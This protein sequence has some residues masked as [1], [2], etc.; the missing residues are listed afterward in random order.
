MG[1]CTHTC[2]TH[3]QTTDNTHTTDLYIPPTQTPTH[4]PQTLYI[5]PRRLNIHTSQ[6]LHTHTHITHVHTMVCGVTH[7]IHYTH[8][9]IYTTLTMDTYTPHIPQL[10]MYHIYHRYK[11]AIHMHTTQT[12]THRHTPMTPDP[13]RD[14]PP[15][16]GPSLHWLLRGWRPRVPQGPHSPMRT[17]APEAVLEPEAR[18]SARSCMW[19]QACLSLGLWE[20]EPQGP[21][22]GQRAGSWRVF[23]LVPT[24]HTLPSPQVTLACPHKSHPPALTG[25]SCCLHTPPPPSTGFPA[26]LA[27]VPVWNL[28]GENEVIH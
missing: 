17:G 16:L 4:T 2:I 26:F 7:N 11:H 20:A 25:L 8:R 10:Y 15:A 28:C 14:S 9:L 23:V 13:T 22:Q 12:Y 21:P 6:T 18:L 24:G 3:A 5:P 1:E 27:V 19:G